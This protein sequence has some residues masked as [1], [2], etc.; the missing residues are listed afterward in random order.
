MALETG[1]RLAGNGDAHGPD[2]FMTAERAR[3]VALGAG[4]SPEG[5]EKIRSDMAAFVKRI[6]K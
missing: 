5:Y 6:T 3:I 4:V 1:A 2:D